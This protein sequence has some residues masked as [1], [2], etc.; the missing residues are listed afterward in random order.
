MPTFSFASSAFGAGALIPLMGI[1]PASLADNV[2]G[3]I[4]AMV[5]GRTTRPESKV[6]SN[7]GHKYDE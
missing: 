2:G 6:P 1:I 7:E 4:P 3:P 5:A